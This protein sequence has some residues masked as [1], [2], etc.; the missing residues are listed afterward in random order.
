[1]TPTI[2][3][4][5]LKTRLIQTLYRMPFRRRVV[6]IDRHK[7]FFSLASVAI[8]YTVSGNPLKIETLILT[9]N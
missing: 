3:I 9:R 1:M 7:L 4:K 2:K 6:H 8:H 5:Q